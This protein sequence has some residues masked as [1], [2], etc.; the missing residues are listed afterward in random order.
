[1]TDEKMVSEREAVMRERKAWLD[2]VAE[3]LDKSFDSESEPVRWPP[4][5]YNGKGFDHARASWE[6][7]SRRVY[8]LP[9]I[10]RPR[11]VR[12]PYATATTTVEWS[13]EKWHDGLVIVWRAKWAPEWKLILSTDT[14]EDGYVITPERVKLWA[15]LLANPTEEVSE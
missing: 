6:E 10:T 11:V 7:Q 15:D 8:P 3:G 9:K 5:Y 13:T 4:R 12:D 14:P 1:M 2:G